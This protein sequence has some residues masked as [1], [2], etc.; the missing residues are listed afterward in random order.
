MTD[1]VGTNK[2][3]DNKKIFDCL[4]AIERAFPNHERFT[5]GDLFLIVP[6]FPGGYVSLREIVISAASRCDAL[7]E[8][9]TTTTTTKD[10]EEEEEEE[11][12]IETEIEEEFEQRSNNNRSS[13]VSTTSGRRRRFDVVFSFPRYSRQIIMARDAQF[14]ASLLRRRAF[15][16]LYTFLRI[17][18]SLMLIIS[19]VVVALALIAMLILV[20]AN[21]RGDSRGGG[22]GDI[23]LFTPGYGPG[24]GPGGGGNMDGFWMYLYMR[25]IMWLSYWDDLERRRVYLNGDLYNNSGIVT[26]V[27][28]KQGRDGG[29]GDGGGGDD[30][31]NGGSNNNNNNNNFP[32]PD[33]YRRSMIAEEDDHEED[34]SNKTKELSFIESIY[35]FVFGRGDPNEFLEH[36]RSKAISQLLRVN[37]GVVFAE[38]LASFTDVFLLEKKD[39]RKASSDFSAFF[40]FRNKRDKKDDAIN[41]NI[42]IREERQHEGYVL[43][44]L[45]QFHGYAEANDYGRLVYIFPSFQVTAEQTTDAQIAKF[46][47]PPIPPPIYEKKKPVFEFGVKGPLVIFTG[48]FNIFL[49]LLFYQVGG[50]DFK[51]PRRTVTRAQMRKSMG[52]RGGQFSEQQKNNLLTAGPEDEEI[53][54][55][56]PPA[57]IAFFE[58]FP[59]LAQFLYAPML[60]Y[61]IFFFLFPLFRAFFISRENKAIARRNAI[62]KVRAKEA[63]LMCVEACEEKRDMALKRRK[64]ES[65]FK[66]GEASYAN[67]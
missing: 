61:A 45:A 46:A 67:V 13:S 15:R 54:V 29:A 20:L 36:E 25:D 4:R 41:S 37:Q 59:K 44:I 33:I 12:G 56:Q 39:R 24:G 10:G 2:D 9:T 62:R 52:R 28:V 50:L 38:Q 27:P 66:G 51:A 18:F 22:G 57:L 64:R 58:I 11:E 16:S 47:P 26:G 48:V 7:V 53:I 21:G 6:E 30:D 55:E 49:L 19:V 1:T 32:D 17:S 40:S 42:D 34:E 8:T 31:D 14:K 3:V 5:V 23:P 65:V 63:L 35:A 43:R 60:M